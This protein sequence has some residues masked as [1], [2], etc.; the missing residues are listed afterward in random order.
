MISLYTNNNYIEI[1]VKYK[2]YNSLNIFIDEVIKSY[3]LPKNF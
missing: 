1:L 3:S 2:L